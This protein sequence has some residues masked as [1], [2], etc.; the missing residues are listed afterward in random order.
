MLW[1]ALPCVRS[2]IITYNKETMKMHFMLNPPWY[3]ICFV[4]EDQVTK[5]CRGNTS[6]RVYIWGSFAGFSLYFLRKSLFPFL[7]LEGKVKKWHK[8]RTDSIID[9]VWIISNL[10]RRKQSACGLQIYTTVKH[11]I[12]R[13]LSAKLFLSLVKE[14]SRKKCDWQQIYWEHLIKMSK[15]IPVVLS[16][17]SPFKLSSYLTAVCVFNMQQD[18]WVKNRAV[19]GNLLLVDHRTPWRCSVRLC[20]FRWFCS[21][22]VIIVRIVSGLQAIACSP[23]TTPAYPQLTSNLQQTKNETTNVVMNI[24]VASSW[25]WA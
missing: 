12:Y 8:I 4:L 25:W 22:F 23:D 19:E 20:V 1:T 16:R 11:K 13:L 2:W 3:Q 9:D 7:M 15:G 6:R 14:T 10:R 5:T 18:F 24:I 17:S 21:W